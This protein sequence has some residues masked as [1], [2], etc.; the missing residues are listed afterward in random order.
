MTF[1]THLAILDQNISLL[2][3][4]SW[5][6]R[7][8][9]NCSCANVGSTLDRI[10]FRML[11]SDCKIHKICALSDLQCKDQGMLG[12]TI[13]KSHSFMCHTPFVHMLN[14]ACC[15]KIFI[16]PDFAFSFQFDI[17]GVCSVWLSVQGENVN[18]YCRKRGQCQ[19]IFV[20]IVRL[21]S[22]PVV[23]HPDLDC[24][25]ADLC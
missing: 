10:P 19:L 5:Q 7:V 15:S 23:M 2:F 20:T 24:L 25:F 22:K 3:A 16:I 8:M 17:T 13:W 14:V 4:H 9:S 21:K 18:F 12:T 1:D 6:R 11:I